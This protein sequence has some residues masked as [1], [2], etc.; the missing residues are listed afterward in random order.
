[1]ELKD[2]II[3]PI[4]VLVLY[5]IAILIRPWVTYDENRKYF[6]PAFSLKLLGAL[7]LGALYQF[8]YGGGDTFGYFKGATQ[9]FEAFYDEP[10]IALKL[11]FNDNNYKDG[12]YNYA[13]RI[14]MY[15][16]AATY[17]VVRIAGI[18]AILT[19]GTYSGIALLF[20]VVSFS[21]LWAMY[22]AFSKLFPHYLLGLAIAILFIPSTIF[23]G[24]G[25]LKDSI[26]F[27][28]L[29]WSTAALIN[30]LYW[31]RRPWLWVSVLL[32]S[33]LLAFKIKEYIVLSFI[34]AAMIWAYFVLIK[35]VSNKL[36]RLLVAPVVITLMLFLSG[37]TIFKVGETSSRY[38]IKNMAETARITAYDVGRYTGRNAGSRYDLGDF[39][40]NFSS[41][42]RLAPAAINVSLYRPYLWE[43]RG[44]LM[45]LA[46][47]EGSTLLI[48]TIIILVRVFWYKIN[49]LNSPAAWFSLVFSLTFAFAVGI[50]TYNFGTL[51]RYKVP[52]MPF[53][54]ILLVLAWSYT[55]Q[56]IKKSKEIRV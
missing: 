35:K 24:S 51:F 54:A 18:F 17:M 44:P 26:T 30:L 53:F 22:M 45:L 52:L 23:W 14:W 8:Y 38:S 12:V 25:I 10:G 29:G 9:I 42:M 34:P 7:L 46:A 16:D 1:M 50:S 31:Q 36:L 27:G 3:A 28:M 6:L 49:V 20:A 4:V 56:E 33:L 41:M 43:V 15:K 5:G 21:G 13:S 48:L 32:I 47:L 55:K 39:E 40:G 11:I 37:Y 2:L 19:G